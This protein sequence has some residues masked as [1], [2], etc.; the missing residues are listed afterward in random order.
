MKCYLFR[1]Q[2]GLYAMTELPPTEVGGNLYVTP[3]DRIGLRHLCRPMAEAIFG[4]QLKR[5]EWVEAD[6]QGQ[7]T[8]H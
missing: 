6:I 3:G 1:E 5:G 4:T 7:V 2:S 8:A